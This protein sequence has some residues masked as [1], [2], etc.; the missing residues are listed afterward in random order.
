METPLAYYWDWEGV[1][2]EFV[3]MQ[4]ESRGRDSLESLESHP[5]LRPRPGLVPMG[6]A[7]ED[8]VLQPLKD[9]GFTVLY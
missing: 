9:Q 4:T 3:S 2:G 6:E 7:P 1:A 5:Q 8:C